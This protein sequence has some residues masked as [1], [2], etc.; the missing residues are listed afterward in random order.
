MEYVQKNLKSSRDE[1]VKIFVDLQFRDD[2]EKASTFECQEYT[3]YVCEGISNMQFKLT[4]RETQCR[5]APHIV[6]TAM[7]LY[8]RSRK[9]YDELRSSGLLCL[10]DPRHLRRISGTMKVGEG[11]D[12]MIYSLFQEEIEQRKTWTL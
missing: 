12:P 11:G 10:P 2:P 3:N 8:L 4:R 6:N 5:F 1:L 9:S 7:S